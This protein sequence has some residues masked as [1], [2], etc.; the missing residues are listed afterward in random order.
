MQ[1]HFAPRMRLALLGTL[2][3]A[4]ACS[5]N[6]SG[7]GPTPTVSIQKAGG[8]QQPG[9][10]GQALP[11]PL[12]VLVTQDGSPMSGAT[13]TW[14]AGTGGGALAPTGPTGSDGIASATW[15]LG[16]TVGNQTASAALQG[17]QGSPLTFTATAAA[18]GGGGGGGTATDQVSVQNNVFSPQVI[19]VPVGTTVTWTWSANALEHNI[20]PNT[21]GSVPN[22]PTISSAPSSY[23]VTFTAPG[24]YDYYC[25]VH[26]SPGAGMHGTVIVQ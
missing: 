8:D 10:A 19:T 2:A 7:A 12:R 4:A 11:A 9:T 15:T 1:T 14:A 23:Q 17:A 6:D 16:A 26:G 22:D 3:L 5:S 20:V 21:A 24:T 25:Q 13:I 18:P